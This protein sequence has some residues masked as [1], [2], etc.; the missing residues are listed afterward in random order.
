MCLDWK[1]NLQ[2]MYNI[3]YINVTMKIKAIIFYK[4]NKESRVNG[5][6]KTSF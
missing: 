5:Y 4:H 2:I 3:N 6:G 1:N